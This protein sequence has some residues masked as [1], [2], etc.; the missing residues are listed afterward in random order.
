MSNL[1][2]RANR[3]N[4]KHSVYTQLRRVG[5]GL[6]SPLFRFSPRACFGWRRMM[7]RLFGARVGRS[8]HVYPS[9]QIMM[10]WNLE[11]GDES[12]VGEAALLYSLGPIRI[13][14]RA[15]ISQRAHLCAATHDFRKRD[16]PLVRLPI[17]IGDEV[18]VCADAFVGPGVTIGHGA[19]A[20]ARA[21]VVKDVAPW[22]VVGGNPAKQIGTRTIEP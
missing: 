20:G 9:A 18:W 1:D 11:I 5:W 19:V 7:L 3:Q 12:A 13:G 8:V 10:P 16:L 2:I 6:F 21:V 17:E 15:T 4:R 22:T 14:S